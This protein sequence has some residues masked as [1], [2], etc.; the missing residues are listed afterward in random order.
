[1]DHVRGLLAFGGQGQLIVVMSRVGHRDH[2]FKFVT[3][4]P[5][6]LRWPRG[7]RLLAHLRT[8]DFESCVHGGH[9]LATGA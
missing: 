3:G 4:V 1:M 8:Q 5:W 6:S 9:S 7:Q 2:H